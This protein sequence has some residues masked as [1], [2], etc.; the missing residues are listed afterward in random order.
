MRLA[1][2]VVLAACGQAYQKPG[3]EPQPVPA[4]HPVEGPP[5]R[6]SKAPTKG[7]PNA[8]ATKVP[9]KAEPKTDAPARSDAKPGSVA[10]QWVD[11]HNRFRAN[12]CAPPL[13]WSSELAKVAQKWADTLKSKGCMFGHSPGAKYGENLAAGTSGALD[14]ESTVAM[15]YDEV[16]KYN[17]KTGAFSME[18]G[19]FTQVVWTTTKSVGC[20]V[21]TCKG[22]DIHVCN[23][24]PPGNWDG[25]FKQHVLPASCKK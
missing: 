21:V 5:P 20:G 17:F 11:A 4:S 22:N 1:A 14:P 8:A 6:S 23:Y 3:E 12:H 7:S 18:T 25:Q 24:D 16:K 9:A 15:W 13:V 19:H 2:L 10:Q